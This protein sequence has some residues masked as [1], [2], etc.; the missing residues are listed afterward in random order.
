[1]AFQA[2]ARHDNDGSVILDTRHHEAGLNCFQPEQSITRMLVEYIVC[3]PS[4]VKQR[5]DEAEEDGIVGSDEFTH[6][7]LPDPFG[8]GPVRM[9]H[10]PGLFNGNGS[11]YI[12]CT[13]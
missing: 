7:A 8:G 11:Q 1:M 3:D 6:K 10:S 12:R 5:T 2:R 13:Q 9:R 4:L